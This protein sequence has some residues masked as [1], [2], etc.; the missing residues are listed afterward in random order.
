MPPKAAKGGTGSA[1]ATTTTALSS[2][3]P[4]TQQTNKNPLLQNKI[5]ALS[6]AVTNYKA[7]EQFLTK[8]ILS[9]TDEPFTLT[10]M[11][12]ILLQITQICNITPLP[13]V[14][15]IR[16]TAFILK[17]HI[18]DEMALEIAS[19]VACQITNT[20]TPHISNHVVG[21]IAPQMAKLLTTSDQ[22]TVTLTRT[23]EI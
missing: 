5:E 14:A 19:E 9:L 7:A 17:K 3:G 10:H 18:V 11:I 6:S 20:L 8:N 12:S 2:V 15:A 13:V 16:V 4:T 22:M 21:A 23:E 1:N